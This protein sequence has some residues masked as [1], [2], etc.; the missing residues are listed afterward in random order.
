MKHLIACSLVA[1]SF[2]SAW[3]QATLG[4]DEPWVRA[5]IG[6]QTATGAFMR[7]TAP[8]DSRVLRVRSPLAGVAEIHEMSMQGD[9]MRMRALDALPLPAG[10][11][12]E[13][14]PGGLHVMLMDLKAPVKA[15]DV[16]PLILTIEGRDGRTSE[17]EVKA[18]ARAL[19][20]AAPAADHGAHHKH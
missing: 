19:N 5:T 12:V 14:Q 11:A 9:V 20:A 18:T 2:S 15:G 10:R 6:Q 8:A 1:L 16:V 7:L 17:I 3:A 13:L 4:V